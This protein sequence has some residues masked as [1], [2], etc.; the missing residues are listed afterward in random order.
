MENVITISKK[1]LKKGELVIVPRE[2]YEEYLIFKKIIPLIEASGADK[3]AI[4][5]GRKEIEKGKYLS[6]R[7]LKNESAN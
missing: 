3:R 4:I 7:Q 5:E 1:L 6:I 2:E